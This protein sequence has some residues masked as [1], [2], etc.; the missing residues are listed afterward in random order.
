[1]LYLI[2]SDWLDLFASDCF[3]IL[4]SHWSKHFLLTGSASV[5]HLPMLSSTNLVVV[6]LLVA[7]VLIVMLCLIMD[8]CMYVSSPS[9]TGGCISPLLCNL[10]C[11]NK[12]NDK[13]QGILRSH[14]KIILFTLF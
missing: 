9:R 1:M 2:K 8:I 3:D 11:G 6:A 13:R 5:I 14:L 12:R 7:I 10:C 4:K